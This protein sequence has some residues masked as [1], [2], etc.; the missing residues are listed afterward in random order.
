MHVWGKYVFQTSICSE[1]ALFLNIF[2]RRFKGVYESRSRKNTELSADILFCVI[3]N[4]HE[5]I[6]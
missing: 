1:R 3:I 4:T 5:V 6:T 2:S